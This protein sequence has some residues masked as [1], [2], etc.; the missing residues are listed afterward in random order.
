MLNEPVK[1]ERVKEPLRML[2]KDGRSIV[3]PNHEG[4]IPPK[5]RG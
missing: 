3:F 4:L 2:L 5:G 1:S